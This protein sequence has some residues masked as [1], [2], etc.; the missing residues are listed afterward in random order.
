MIDL[1]TYAV[2]REIALQTGSLETKYRTADGRFIVD[3]R[4]LRNAGIPADSEGIEEVTQAK[5]REL[6]RKGGYQMGDITEEAGDDSSGE[7]TAEEAGESSS[8]EQA[9]EEVG[10]SSLEEETEEEVSESVSG[11]QTAE[12][13]NDNDNENVNETEDYG[14]NQ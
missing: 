6:I 13:D 7:Q 14:D 1:K 5:A 4:M 3:S 12:K 8:G 11:E 10:E 9:A 2:V